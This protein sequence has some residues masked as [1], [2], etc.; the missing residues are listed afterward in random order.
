MLHVNDNVLFLSEWSTA[1][2][3]LAALD[4]RD[5]LESITLGSVLAEL[6]GSTER[7]QQAPLVAS[8]RLSSTGAG[9][10]LAAGRVA[11]QSGS[12]SAEVPWGHARN[13][14]R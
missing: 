6:V 3:L 8:G 7:V 1:L 4:L 2:P 13:T 11:G 10:D 5:E 9:R 12:R 14:R